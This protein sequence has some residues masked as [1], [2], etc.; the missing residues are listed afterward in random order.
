MVVVARVVGARGWRHTATAADARRRGGRAGPD[1]PAGREPSL[2]ATFDEPARGR[3]SDADS[4]AVPSPVE[5]DPRGA[6]RLRRD[7]RRANRG[8]ALFVRLAFGI[9]RA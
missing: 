2:R 3:R 1:A 7:I 9:C 6:A 4:D 5:P 8:G